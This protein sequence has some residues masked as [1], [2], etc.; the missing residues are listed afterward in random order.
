MIVQENKYTHT[1][2]HTRMTNANN[3]MQYQLTIDSH[4]I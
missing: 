3:F 4:I 1:H 2:T